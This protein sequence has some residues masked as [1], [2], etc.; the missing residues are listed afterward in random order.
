[1]RSGPAAVA[2]AGVVIFICGSASDEDGMRM[3]D[4]A[5]TAAAEDDGRNGI[6]IVKCDS[7]HKSCADDPGEQ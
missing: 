2:G 7:L 3:V 1:V 6:P 4:E 5:V